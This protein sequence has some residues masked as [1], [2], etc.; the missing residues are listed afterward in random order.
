MEEVELNKS[1][2]DDYLDMIIDMHKRF[3]NSEHVEFKKMRTLKKGG[4][5]R[6]KNNFNLWFQEEIPADQTIS[7]TGEPTYINGNC[8]SVWSGTQINVK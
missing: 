4:G 5:I 3:V 6:Y 2:A 7:T 1:K 8:C